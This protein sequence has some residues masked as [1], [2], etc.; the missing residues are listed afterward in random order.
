MDDK[1]AKNLIEALIFSAQEPLSLDNIKKMLSSY[2]KFD[3][4]KLIDQIQKD[5][6]DRGINLKSLEKKFL[7]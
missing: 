6:S 4:E 1:Q 2:G 5:Y 7:L 3:V